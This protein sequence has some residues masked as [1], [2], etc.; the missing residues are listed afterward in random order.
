MRNFDL[1]FSG[2][3]ILSFVLSGCTNNFKTTAE[4]TDPF[5]KLNRNVFTFNK[6]ALNY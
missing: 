1:V 5:E 3:F 6:Y 4:N 2:I